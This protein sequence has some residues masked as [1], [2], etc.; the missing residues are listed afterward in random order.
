M[1]SYMQSY[2]KIWLWDKFGVFLRGRQPLK[3][4]MHGE[5]HGAGYSVQPIKCVILSCKY[6]LDMWTYTDI[7][8]T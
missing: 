2:N 3:N 6:A 1:L 8:N 7:I 4:T 5:Q